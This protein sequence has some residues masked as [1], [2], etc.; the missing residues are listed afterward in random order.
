MEFLTG[1]FRQFLLCFRLMNI[2]IRHLPYRSVIELGMMPVILF[3]CSCSQSPEKNNKQVKKDPAPKP[4]IINKPPSS[5]GDSVVI[6][7]QA[8]VFY[9]PDSLQMEKIK[10]VNEM[11]VYATITHDCYYLMQNARN[12]IRQHWPRIRIVEVIK[13]R[14][15]L[16]VK[17]DKSKICIDLNVKNN[18]CGIFLFDPKKD[19]E[20]VDMPNIDTALGFYFGL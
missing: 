2:K 16:F 8:A 19:P 4:R 9:N 3:A 14:Y 10:A 17:K 12:V 13:A 6:D 11:R 5:F 7:G 20:P 18:I 15:L 1:W